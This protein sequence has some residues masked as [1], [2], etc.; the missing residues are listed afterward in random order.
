MKTAALGIGMLLF[1][2]GALFLFSRSLSG[3]PPAEPQ[4]LPG[5][6][7]RFGFIRSVSGNTLSFDEARWLT[8]KEGEDAAIAAG[9]CTEATRTEC[10]PNDFFIENT[11]TSTIPLTLADEP[12]IA[13]FT[14]TMEHEGVK[15]TTISKEQ[16]AT[17][18]NDAHAHWAQLPYQM[19]VDQGKVT[20]IE[21]VYV[22]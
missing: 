22:P 19:L 3:Q 14:L 9:H 2:C 8:G 6:G 12:E 7:I 11:S 18:I 10:L 17:L 1:I 20:I 13:M 4:P 5:D 21:E 15:E 16:L